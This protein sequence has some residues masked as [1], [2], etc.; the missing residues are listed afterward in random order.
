MISLKRTKKEIKKTRNVEIASDSSYDEYPWGTKLRF[1][2]DEISKIKE[3]QGLNV[4]DSVF[5]NAIGSVVEKS[6]HSRTKGKDNKTIEI[7]IEKISIDSKAE[8]SKGF[9]EKD[10]ED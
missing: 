7:Q 1:E 4:G 9:N 10:D 6:E 5:I 8:E 2:E 3:I